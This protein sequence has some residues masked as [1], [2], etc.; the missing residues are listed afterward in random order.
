MSRAAALL[1]DEGSLLAVFKWKLGQL[2]T[3]NRWYP[4]LHRHVEQI[5]RR[6]GA[7]GGNPGQI[8]PSPTGY[9]PPRHRHEPEP[10]HDH[11]REHAQ[12]RTDKVA[13]VVYD[14]LGDFVGFDL[15]GDDHV[16]RYRSHEPELERLVKEAWKSR[17]VVTV[18]PEP[19]E[20]EEPAGI[21]LRRYPMGDC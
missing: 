13:G 18:V 7:M 9:H 14:R 11:R 5:E 8:P 10:D 19:E 4:V 17:I 20:P 1:P 6:V 3:A 21:I 2:P 12:E 16:H 15:S